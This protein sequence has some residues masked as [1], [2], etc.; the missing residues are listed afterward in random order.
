EVGRPMTSE[1]RDG[2]TPR[3]VIINTLATVVSSLFGVGA[4]VIAIIAL[5]RTG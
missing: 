4:L 2:W 3:W 5:L 1:H